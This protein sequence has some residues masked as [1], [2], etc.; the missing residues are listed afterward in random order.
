MAAAMEKAGNTH[1]V[2]CGCG[3]WFPAADALLQE[4]GPP[5]HCPHC[6]REFEPGEAKRIERAEEI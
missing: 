2:E 6:H 1:W 4:D 3:T 5:L